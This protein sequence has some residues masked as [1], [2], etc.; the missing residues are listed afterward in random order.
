MVKACNCE[1]YDNEAGRAMTCKKVDVKELSGGKKKMRE[2]TSVCK[3]CGNEA[4][5]VIEFGS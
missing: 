1:K 2:E 4:N 3:V 5:M